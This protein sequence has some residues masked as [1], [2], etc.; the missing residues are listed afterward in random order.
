MALALVIDDD[1]QVRCLVAMMLKRAG[2]EVAQA[3]DGEEGIGQCAALDPEVIATDIVMP[4]HDGI[5]ILCEAK[6]RPRQPRVVAISG[7]SPRLQVDFLQ[8]AERLGA[9][10]VVQ[11]P[12][13]PAQLLWAVTGDPQCA[14]AQGSSPEAR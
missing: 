2:Y 14:S 1:T 6:A 4:R 11:K 12:F 7:G 3:K 9:D 13:T 8:V 5:D 10:A